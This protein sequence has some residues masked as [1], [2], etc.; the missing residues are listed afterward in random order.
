MTVLG[1][2]AQKTIDLATGQ[3]FDG[4]APCI[5]VRNVEQTESEIT[6]TYTFD[7][8]ILENVEG[9]SDE[10]YW[11]MNGFGICTETGEPAV[12][13]TVDIYDVSPFGEVTVN[14]TAS[15]YIELPYKIAPTREPSISSEYGDVT[16]VAKQVTS[17]TYPENIVTTSGAYQAR[18]KVYA[19]VTLCPLQYN[20]DTKTTR[21]YRSITYVIKPIRP[22]DA[23]ARVSARNQNGEDEIDLHDDVMD[24]VI[25]NP[26]PQAA[27]QAISYT[28]LKQN[29][30]L[31]IVTSTE[32]EPAVRE[33]VEH[34]QVLGF[35][36]HL[37]SFPKGEK[38]KTIK[39]SIDTIKK[40]NTN[41]KYL[42]IVGDTLHI[43]AK[44]RHDLGN[45]WVEPHDYPMDFFYASNYSEKV[46]EMA[47]GRIPA[48]NISEARIM[49]NKIV[50]YELTPP[51]DETFYNTATHASFF[52]MC[53]T[54]QKH[55]VTPLT[56]AFFEGVEDDTFN[57]V[58]VS[59]NIR[60]A[61]IT[62]YKTNITRLYCREDSAVVDGEKISL[63][64]PQYWAKTKKGDY[65]RSLP[66]IL[67][68]STTYDFKSQMMA[69]A[70]NNGTNYVLYNA[71]GGAGSQ[72]NVWQTSTFISNNYSNGDK[73]PV[74][75]GISCL[76]GAYNQTE[77]SSYGR[78]DNFVRALL[79]HPNG[80]AVGAIA[81]TTVS[82]VD[83][84]NI[85]IHY[86]FDALYPGNNIPAMYY[87]RESSQTLP[88]YRMGDLLDH[89]LIKTEQGFI[90]WTGFHNKVV[91][92][93]F[94]DP[95]MRIRLYKPSSVTDDMVSVTYNSTTKKYMLNVYVP[96]YME[97]S[98]LK[99]GEQPE[100]YLGSISGLEIE[101][102]R[103]TNY[104]LCINGVNLIP[105]IINLGADNITNTNLYRLKV[106]YN[107]ASNTI[108]STYIVNSTQST[109]QLLV[110]SANGL[111]V[112][113]TSPHKATGGT[114]TAN[115]SLPFSSP[116]GAYVVGLIVD[117][118]CVASATV[119]K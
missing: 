101:N 28:N 6:V 63:P 83:P 80:G 61:L 67:K 25:S 74:Y 11:H 64:L 52:E 88:I 92:H 114:E 91:Y 56:Y 49:L 66:D 118:Q 10:F 104:T 39:D 3:I 40:Y 16:D 97:V 62:K 100:R 53:D 75:F 94:G 116:S 111:F 12:L 15:D 20:V 55:P 119:V 29:E 103:T 76:L 82:Y 95:T 113:S 85:F 7:Y 89:A 4:E 54:T 107:S 60:E 72:S 73:L 98:L 41:I 70:F 106:S 14:V 110:Y 33:Y 99:D 112:G 1:A 23:L 24:Y 2:M 81:A 96:N 102:P 105:K 57:F 108:T 21:A 5:P 84:N 34:K 50:N 58:R 18:G 26:A 59:E 31:L 86:L 93:Y 42:F 69:D 47:R 44:K 109:V 36:T 27:A 35:Q 78:R 117:G 51:T 13:G 38:F 90:H 43:T 30:G 115:I 9:K 46:P 37:K 17:G 8:A 48:K 65:P 79:K 68:D 77:P 71:H 45:E 32:L 22:L 19:H 87:L